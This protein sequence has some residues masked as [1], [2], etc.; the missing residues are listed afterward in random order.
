MGKTVGFIGAG[1]MAEALARGFVAKG[2]LKA[3][4]IS[5]TDPSQSRR[6]VFASMGAKAVDSSAEASAGPEIRGQ[7]FG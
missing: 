5:A 6:D 7:P 4:E 2:V 3:S 1:Q